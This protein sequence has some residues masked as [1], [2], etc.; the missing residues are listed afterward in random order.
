MK[1]DTE[2]LTILIITGFI[3]LVNNKNYLLNN[4][5]Q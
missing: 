1:L 4:F 2:W 3:K 5:V